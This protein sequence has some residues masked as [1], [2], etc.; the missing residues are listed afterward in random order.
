ML[1]KEQ[2]INE[3]YQD[4]GDV[5]VQKARLYVKTKRAEIEKIHYENENNFEIQLEEL[6]GDLEEEEILIIKDYISPSKKKLPEKVLEEI[7]KLSHE[8]LMKSDKIAKILGYQE[9]STVCNVME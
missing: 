1:V 4:A 6:V 2:I 3:L 7:E 9:F 8:D 5:R